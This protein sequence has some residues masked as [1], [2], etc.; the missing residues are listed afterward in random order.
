MTN[1]V[2]QDHP[3]LPG[4]LISLEHWNTPETSVHKS[5]RGALN[6][7]LLQLRVGIS[8]DDQAFKSLDDLPMLKGD[9]LRVFAPE[10]DSELLA[11][12]L[13]D[14]W[15]RLR[16]AGAHQR[17]VSFVVAPPFS[18]V[19]E[20]LCRTQRRIL[21]PPDNLF[22]TEQDA[23][24][25]WDEQLAGGDWIVPELADFWLRHQSGLNLL[26]E[27][28]ARIALDHAGNGVV[29]C[30]S[31]CWQFWTQ[32]LPELSL[33]PYTLAPLTG[34]QMT[35][36]F[37]Y[38]ASERGEQQVIARMTHDGLYVLPVPEEK[39][40]LKYSS[41]T[42]DLATLA[43]GNRGIA[44]AI[45]QRALRA[46]PEKS[47]AHEGKENREKREPVDIGGRQCWVVPLDQLSLPSVPQSA[48]RQPGHILHALLLHNGLTTEQLHMVTGLPEQE[49][50]LTLDK[51]LRA[52]LIY[53]NQ[54]SG[55]YE[56]T[57][58]GY[59]AVRKNLQ[60]RGYPVDGF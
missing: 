24:A 52:E 1:D 28:F 43:R 9:K 56:V 31:W 6:D 22:M 35:R 38:L 26:R 23:A 45:W 59:P 18:G 4:G 8:P 25:W 13:Q 3:Y 46:R 14:Q 20:A 32:Y 7:I 39:T 41:F 54:T 50:C 57:P 17:N 40:R 34:E 55:A 33:A 11:K 42:Q 44:R 53:R 60:G 48:G 2:V 36:W 37:D 49:V 47:E 5:L 19:A 27:F 21:T 15:A 30:V 51:L 16:Q 10:P 12:A 58:L 29:G